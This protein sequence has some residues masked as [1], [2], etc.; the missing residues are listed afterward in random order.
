MKVDLAHMKQVIQQH[1]LLYGVMV[2]QAEIND[3]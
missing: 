2:T 3:E 1:K